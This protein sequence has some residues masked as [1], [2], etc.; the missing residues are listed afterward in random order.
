MVK[1][2]SEIK[3]SWIVSEEGMRKY[4]GKWYTTIYNERNVM[5]NIRI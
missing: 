4:S 2:R 3:R 5:I 1:Y